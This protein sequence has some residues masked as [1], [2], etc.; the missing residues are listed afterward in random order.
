MYIG[1]DTLVE[2]VNAVDGPQGIDTSMDI[3]ISAVETV[4]LV[5]KHREAFDAFIIACGYDPGLDACR[6]AVE[7]PVIGLAEAAMLMACT[8]GH[9]FSIFTNND[10][11]NPIYEDLVVHYRLEGRLASIR[12]IGLSTA[13]LSNRD[14]VFERLVELGREVVDKDGAE[15]ILLPGAVMV[16]LEKKLSEIVGVPVL[17]GV[18]CALKM[19][20]GLVDYGQQTSKIGKFKRLK[21]HDVLV[22][23]EDFQEM[24]S[25]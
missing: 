5:T 17:A 6:N 3:V 7:Q 14:A 24:Y 2:C 9:K 16:G 13:E 20:E 22:G 4:R 18:V 23:Y 8:L 12:G 15:V 11:N 21:K 1:R 19:A 10:A 25:A